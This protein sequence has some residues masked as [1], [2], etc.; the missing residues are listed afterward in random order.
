MKG[1]KTLPDEQLG[2]LVI[3]IPDEMQEGQHLSKEYLWKKEIQDPLFYIMVME[4][5]RFCNY[6]GTAKP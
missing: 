1:Y 3:Y 6:F 2:S 5:A 4:K